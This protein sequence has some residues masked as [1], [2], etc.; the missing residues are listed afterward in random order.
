MLPYSKHQAVTELCKGMK[1]K[2]GFVAGV[3]NKL[4]Y[5]L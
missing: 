2:E 1:E 3:K 4:L 5:E